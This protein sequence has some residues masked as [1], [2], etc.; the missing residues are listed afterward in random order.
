MTGKL[1]GG[2]VPVGAGRGLAL[3]FAGF[4]LLNFLGAL[5]FHANFNLNI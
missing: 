5:L 4:G 3:F 1:G 2:A